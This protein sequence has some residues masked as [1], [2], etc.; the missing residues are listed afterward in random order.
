MKEIYLIFKETFQNNELNEFEFSQGF[1]DYLMID[2]F[3]GFMIFVII[4]PLMLFMFFLSRFKLKDFLNKE[5]GGAAAIF[6]VF[7]IGLPFVSM[8]LFYHSARIDYLQSVLDDQFLPKLNEEQV[9]FLKKES[10]RLNQNSAYLTAEE[11]LGFKG[12]NNK[13]KFNHVEVI[14]SRQAVDVIE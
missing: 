11:R 4:V 14:I 10:F 3:A 7:A 8:S 1:L 2:A 13:L 12:F 9:N 5:F 6:L